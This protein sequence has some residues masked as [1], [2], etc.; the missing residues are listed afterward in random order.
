MRKFIERALEKLPKLDKEQISN[1]IFMLAKENELISVVLDSMS[2]GVV[3]LDLEHKISLY[4]KSA[5]RLLPFPLGSEL[6]DRIIW[7]VILDTEIAE[8]IKTALEKEERLE[9]RIFTI[10]T[11]GR[12][13]KTLSISMLPLVGNGTI[14][15]TI[16]HVEDVTEKKIREAR[17]RRAESLASL[18]TLAAGVAHEIKNPLGSIGIHIQLIQKA[19]N[20]NCDAD[21]EAI[22]KYLEVVNEEIERLNGIVMDFLFAVRPMDM[23]LEER[24]VNTLILELCDFVRYELEDAGIKL[25][26]DLEDSLPNLSIDE[27]FFKQAFLNLVKNSMAAMPDGGTLK[28]S[29]KLRGDSVV[30]SIKDY[31]VGISE[32]NLT[33][34]F[35]P[36]FTTKDFGSGLGLTL[37]YKIVKEHNGEINLKSKEGEG[38]EIIISLPV[39]QKEPRLLGWGEREDEI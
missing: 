28:V 8:C 34:V 2:D 6:Y 5:E 3:A 24:D 4:N 13:I 30:I 17:L 22:Q 25:K 11:G 29:T 26:I 35:E 16:I 20:K 27:K 10:D 36:F 32:E 7:Q 14:K 31:G 12:S 19:L 1:L 37:V 38:T 21:L 39:P 9:E 33:K 18:T 23:N 15:G